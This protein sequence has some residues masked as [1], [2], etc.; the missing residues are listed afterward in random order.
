M[1]STMQDAPLSITEIMKYGVACYPESK[2]ITYFGDHSEEA[3]FSAVG[4]RAAKLANALESLGVE[5]GDRVGTFCFNHQQHME[6]YLGVPSMGAVLHTLNLRLFPDQLSYVINDADDKYI[7]VDGIVLPLLARVLGD[8]PGVKGL[9][10]VGPGNTSVLAN[11]DLKVFDYEELISS[12]DGTYKWPDLDEKSAAAMCYTSGTTGRPKGVAYSHRS[13]F[14][15]SFAAVT[16]NSIGISRNDNVLVIVPMFHANA[17]GIPYGAFM[18]GADM[19]MPNR[20]LQAAPLADMI[21]QFRPTLGSGVPT[22]WN[23]LYH[24]LEENPIDMSCFRLISSGG[25]AMPESLAFGYKERFGVDVVQGWGMTE[26]SPIVTLAVPP[27]GVEGVDKLRYENTAGK[28]VIGTEIRIVDE[29]GSE[30]PHDGK[31]IGELEVRGPWIT[32][33]YYNTDSKESFHE[34]WLRTG[35]MATIDRE[36][37]MRIVDRTK[38]VIKSGGEWVSSVELENA[39]MAHEGVREAAVVGVPDAKWD[40]RPLA[41]VVMK[42]Q[43]DVTPAELKEFLLG[44]VAKWWIPE[45]WCFVEDIP[46]TSV[47]KFDKKALRQQVAE[48]HLEILVV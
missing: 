27:R 30:L 26:T 9:V 33:S 1:K 44:R 7:V 47:G 3:S 45:R 24:Y 34:G 17:W 37:Y 41:F 32:A 13:I 18:S 25:A 28:P 12:F 15:H 42:A 11:F 43:F 36:F 40:E 39:I 23:D 46:K 29:N 16:A 14:L 22:I 2:V 10:V 5:P 8:T 6:A 20:F 31:S 48:G 4:E 35:D 38:D 21:S 19:V